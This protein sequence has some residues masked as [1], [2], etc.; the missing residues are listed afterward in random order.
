MKILAKDGKALVTSGKAIIPPTVG[1][2]VNVSY[3]TVEPNRYSVNLD[4]NT[5]QLDLTGL[6]AGSHYICNMWFRGEALDQDN[7]ASSGDIIDYNIT[8]FD[9]GNEQYDYVFYACVEFSVS[10]PIQYNRTLVLNL[11]ALLEYTH[12]LT[13]YH[14]M[15]Y[16]IT[17]MIQSI[18]VSWD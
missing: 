4:N 16:T 12:N 10:A 11:D 5:V 13:S 8:V 3:N 17:E 6:V 2:T 15:A 9:T 1:G 14:G 7:A 18:V